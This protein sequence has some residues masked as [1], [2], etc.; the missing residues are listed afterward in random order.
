MGHSKSSRYIPKFV[1]QSKAK[2]ITNMSETQLKK[3]V[4]QECERQKDQ[5]YAEV[6][7][8]VLPQLMAVCLYSFELKGYRKQRLQGFIDDVV[9]SF[10]LL[11][12]GAFGKT[13]D[14]AELIEHFKQ[15][16]G[17]D[18]DKELHTKRVL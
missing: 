7:T 4:V 6:V 3:M 10:A 2:V 9:A 13:F 17:I 11:N 5:M 8:D 18:L 1:P 12:V 14:P 16:Y 15:K